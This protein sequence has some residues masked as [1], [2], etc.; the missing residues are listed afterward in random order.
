MMHE[1]NKYGEELNLDQV[2]IQSMIVPGDL[3]KIETHSYINEIKSL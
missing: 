2:N 3:D 1:I